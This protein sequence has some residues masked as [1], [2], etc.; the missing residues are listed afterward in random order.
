[1]MRIFLLL[2]SLVACAAAQNTAPVGNYPALNVQVAVGTQQRAEKGSFYRKTMTI[3]PKMTIDGVARMVPIPAAEATML[4][5]TMDTRAKYKDNTEVYKVLTAE[6]IP[7]PEA[8]TGDR[9]T[10]AFV[11]SSVTYDAYRD[12][13]N[14]GGDVYKYYVFALRD[15]AT[16]AI[17]DFKTN[18]PPL[19]T[20]LKA[21]PEKRADFLNYAAGSK[22]PSTFK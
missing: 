5:I 3:G 2:L 7:I 14:V 10:F 4:I 17:L 22:F 11:E 19:L 18:N 13:S 6:T 12:N 16:K 21:H 1:M 20:F 9:R 15:P 8:R